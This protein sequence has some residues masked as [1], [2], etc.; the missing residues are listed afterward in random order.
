MAKEWQISGKLCMITGANSGI[1]KATA[2]GLAGLGARVV[3]VCRNKEKGEA[4]LDEVIAKSG[5]ESVELM[6]AELSSKKAIR[7]LADD[8]RKKHK[9]LH[10]LINNAGALNSKRVETMDGLE[11]TFAVNHL[12]Y[13]LLTNLLLDVLK[14]SA[15]ARVI[16]VSSNVHHQGVINFDDL[17]AKFRYNG[18]AAYNQSK[19]ANVLF[20]YEL[21]RRLIGTGVT[22]NCLHPGVV[23]TNFGMEAT[24]FTAFMIRLMH[25][26][27]LS[28]EKGAEPLIYL[29][30][31]P[32]TFNGKYFSRKK[33]ERSSEA[34]YDEQDAKRLWEV[35]AEL[36]NLGKA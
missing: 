23:R 10:V 36:T 14:L 1:G 21:A 19:L 30:S 28:Q 8:Y 4:A 26:F 22:A 34:S 16:N 11:M 17:Q 25:P 7:R 2:I 32:E 29:A 35:S 20:T 27:F 12:A 13:F 9:E 31:T 6:L 3:M 18:T 33:E 5:N 24:G 15:P